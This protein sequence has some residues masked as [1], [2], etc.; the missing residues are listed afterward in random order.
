ML[1]R[2][3]RV[4]TNLSQKYLPDAFVFALILTLVVFIAGIFIEEKSPLLMIKY[5]GDGF[6]NLLKF[7]MQMA[8]VLITGF[9]LA[10]TKIVSIALKRIAS[11]ATNHSTG[12]L[13]VTI[14]SLIACYINWGFGLIVSA[15]I[16]VEVSKKLKRV[17]FGLMIASAYSGFLVWHG[18]LS[19]SIPLKL[20]SPTKL[21]KDIIGSDSI[22]VKETLFSSFNLIILF[23]IIISLLII[24]YFLSKSSDN[25]IPFKSI[26]EKKINE[27]IDNTFSGKLE[28]SKFLL[29]IINVLGIIYVSQHFYFGGSF[30]LNIMIFLFLI[31]SMILNLTPKSFLFSFNNSV[32]DSSGILLQ[33]PF[34]AGIMGMMASS[35]LAVSMSEYFISISNEKTF[36]F[37]TYISAGIVNFFVPSGGG[38]WAIQGPIILPVAKELGVSFSKASMAIAWGDAWTNLVQPFWALPLL[39]IGNIKLKDMMGYCVV[40]FVLIGLLTSGILL[41]LS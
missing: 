27:Q 8:L 35:G 31:L 17:N 7:S 4:F 12:V 13:L 10:K 5:W 21:I 41:V 11:L 25:I 16:A 29:C 6:W 9:T 38:Q 34:Y 15:L 14:V 37:F 22:S 24:N 33:F 2:L 20:T 39:S 1:N 19:G 40:I 18:G 26:E 3:T 36:L 30:N 32:K 28:N 23:S